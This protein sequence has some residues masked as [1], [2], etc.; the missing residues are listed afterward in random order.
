[1]LFFFIEELVTFIIIAAFFIESL[2]KL[3]KS[4]VSGD[5]TVMVMV[6]PDPSG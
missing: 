6:T 2:Y 5:I 3:M 1:M 4:S